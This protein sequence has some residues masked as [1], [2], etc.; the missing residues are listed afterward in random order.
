M[1]Y[2]RPRDLPVLIGRGL[3][4]VVVG[5][6]RYVL[7]PLLHFI[8][9]GGGC[10]YYPTCSEYTFEAVQRHGL[11]KGSWLGMRRLLRCHP[12]GGHGYDPVPEGCSC[13]RKRDAHD[14]TLLQPAQ[15]HQK[16]P[17]APS[18]PLS[19]G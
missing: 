18:R 1:K 10:R 13:T 12:W 19:N 16:T 15:R 2:P 17:V 5:F 3:G 11:L 14:A 4:R 9:P 8:A 7:S 6:Y